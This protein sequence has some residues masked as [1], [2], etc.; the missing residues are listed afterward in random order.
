MIAP[1]SR[2]ASARRTHLPSLLIHPRGPDH[3]TTT[4]TISLNLANLI[5]RE[6]YFALK[7]IKEYGYFRY[8]LIHEKQETLCFCFH[9]N[10]SCLLSYVYKRGVLSTAE[11]RK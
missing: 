4:T 5:S 1:E 11:K 6:I 2:A 9:E 8:E 3:D 7:K 10:F